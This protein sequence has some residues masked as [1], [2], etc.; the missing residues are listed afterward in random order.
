MTSL[1]LQKTHSPKRETDSRPYPVKTSIIT[2]EVLGSH[3]RDHGMA[4]KERE[5]QS[6]LCGGA[7][8]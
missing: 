5:G 8:V 3:G 6:D 7:G 2:E 1:F 4:E